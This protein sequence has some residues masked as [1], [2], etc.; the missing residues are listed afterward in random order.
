VAALGTVAWVATSAGL[1][2]YD[3]SDP[4]LPKVLSVTGQ[5]HI[6]DVA[7]SGH[8]AFLAAGAAGLQIVDASD[9]AE[10]I[11]LTQPQ[12]VDVNG[13]PVT[14]NQAHGV[15]VGAVPT[16]T[17]L[18]VADGTNG[19]RAVNVSTLFDPFRGRVGQPAAPISADHAALTLES[20]DPLTPR[21]QSAGIDQLPTLTF[22]THGSA[23][24]L[25]RGSSL[26]RISDES[27]RRLRD[28]WNPGNGVLSRAK[29]D[30][31]R[32]TVIPLA[33]LSSQ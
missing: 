2:A 28:S 21:D 9:P 10:P 19:L 14:I 6:E 24:A 17:W 3:I 22:A 13:A 1:V 33:S 25:A 23:R 7:L 15:A 4:K 26:D 12:V 20:R 16:Q 8:L 5:N 18:F 32:A 31:M 27:G 11:V 29:M 30:A